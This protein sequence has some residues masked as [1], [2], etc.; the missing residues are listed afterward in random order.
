MPA[1]RP[2]K[3]V[4]EQQR[5]AA[6]KAS[7]TYVRRSKYWRLVIP[8]LVQYLN[9]PSQLLRLKG[10][11]LNLLLKRQTDLQYYK[12][13]VQTHVTT[14]VPH[15]D[16]FLHYTRSVQKSLNRFDY[17]VKHGNLTRYR[18]LNAAILAYGDKQD[19][20][21]LTNLPSDTSRV[22][23]VSRLQRDPYVYLQTQMMKDP[24]GFNLA[25]FC[26]SN[27]YFRYLRGFTSL[28]SKLRIHQQAVC[29]LR[30]IERPGIPFIDRSLIVSCL[31]PDQLRLYDSWPGYQ[32]IVDFL[33]HIPIY[34]TRRPTHTP[35]L[36][37]HGRPRV[38]KTSL[39]QTLQACTAVY[40]VGTQNWFPKF[41]NHVYKLMFWDQCRLGM[42]TWQQ[43]LILLD[44][45]PYDLPYK[46]GSTL[47]HDNQLWILTSNKSVRQHLKQK[48]SYL[49]QNF[50]DPLHQ[51]VVQTSFRKRV[52]QV[53]VPPERDLFLLVKLLKQ[54][55]TRC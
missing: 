18:T 35:N 21:A 31:S 4:T 39:V 26:A 45:R 23:Q 15:L 10:D 16:V 27:S 25:A 48:H 42:M 34:G 6:K 9:Q 14:G 3:Y 47:K 17:L 40:P 19:S 46:G 54:A 52:V 41:S 20:S 22:V 24:Y 32:T 8:N 37:I 30:L 51:N 43:M 7:S 38:G 28:A 29:N 55:V 12:I 36:F 50:D 11:T 2:R 13:A 53:S 44:G 49:Q 33:N 1:G 5:K